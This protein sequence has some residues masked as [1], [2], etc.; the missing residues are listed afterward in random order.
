MLRK[1]IHGA[2]PLDFAGDGTMHFGGN[3]GHL[4]RKYAPGLGGEFR[5]N[6]R[7]LVADLL[8]RKVETLGG[9]RL[10]VFPEIDPALNGLGLRHDENRLKLRELSKLAV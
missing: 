9:H 10:V 3:A 5:E 6:L 4:A 8:E 1:E 2:R 7:I